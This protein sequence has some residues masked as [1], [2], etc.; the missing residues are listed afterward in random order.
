MI[1]KNC[2]GRCKTFCA[3]AWLPR[4][5]Y[6]PYTRQVGLHPEA[7]TFFARTPPLRQNRRGRGIMGYYQQAAN[8]GD[9]PVGAK[10]YDR[11]AGNVSITFAR[12]R[13]GIH[14]WGHN[15]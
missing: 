14:E 2:V 7:T 11:T 1:K 12:I 4:H 10:I 13:G 6:R 3:G 15:L 9:V 5:R 8:G